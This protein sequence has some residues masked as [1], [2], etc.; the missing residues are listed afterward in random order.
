MPYAALTRL[1]FRAISPLCLRLSIPLYPFGPSGAADAQH[2]R[3]AGPAGV[4]AQGRLALACAVWL[5]G[6]VTVPPRLR[7]IDRRPADCSVAR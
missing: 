5:P 7:D 3:A 4:L 2:G 1:S 6:P